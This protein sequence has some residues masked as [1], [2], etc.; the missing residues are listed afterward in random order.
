MCTSNSNVMSRQVSRNDLV[1]VLPLRE[2]E[3]TVRQWTRE[4][5]D[6]LAEWPKYPFPYEGLEFSFRGMSCPGKGDVFRARQDKRDTIVL[7]ADHVDQPVIGYVAP[8]QISWAERVVGNV[9]LRVHPAWCNRGVGTGMLRLLSHW[10]FGFGFES[11]RLDVAASNIRAIRCYEKVGFMR[12]GELWRGAPDLAGVD[13]GASRYESLR[14]HVRM[15][16]AT[17]QLRFWLMVLGTQD[18]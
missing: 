15:K 1:R 12:T 14:P 2:T 6:V 17:P 5:M 9:G 3:L 8:N 4:D 10:L 13:L 16:E 7:V 11:I 18:R